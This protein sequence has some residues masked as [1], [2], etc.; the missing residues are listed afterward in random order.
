MALPLVVVGFAITLMLVSLQVT[1]VEEASNPFLPAGLP[2]HPLAEFLADS[3]AEERMLAFLLACVVAPVVEETIFRG[4]LYRHLR[5]ASRNWQRWASFL[6]SGVTS[7]FV[8]A[9]IHPQGLAAVPALMALAFGFAIAREWRDSLIPCMVGHGLSNAI[10][11]LV[12]LL[13]VVD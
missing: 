9:V 13:A 8:F 6:V 4:V 1:A 10:V 5:E 3:S 7:S 2:S 11:T 12:I